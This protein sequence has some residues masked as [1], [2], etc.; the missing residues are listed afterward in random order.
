MCNSPQNSNLWMT[1]QRVKDI[2]LGKLESIDLY[3][4]VDGKISA[5]V[6][7]NVGITDILR[8]N[9]G[10]YSSFAMVRDSGLRNKVEELGNVILSGLMPKNGTA[11]AVDV[12]DEYVEFV[13]RR[14]VDFI[15]GNDEA[16][17]GE[18]SVKEGEAVEDL[19]GE[20]TNL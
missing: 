15:G 19:G 2:A 17:G 9:L 12:T 6:K 1:L 16:L 10:N 4:V 11:E 3:A 13:D 5:L 14:S 7:E 20:G 18:G 8:L